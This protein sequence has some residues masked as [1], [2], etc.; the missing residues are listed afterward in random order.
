MRLADAEAQAV[1][2][3]ELRRSLGE[4]GADAEETIDELRSLA[5]GVYPAVSSTTVSR[6]P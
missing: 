3:D 6:P 2:D 1:S 5:H 4:L